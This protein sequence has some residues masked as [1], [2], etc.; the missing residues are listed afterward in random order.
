MP[1]SAPEMVKPDKVTV[2]PVPA[3]LL[4]KTPEAPLVLMLEFTVSP[5][6]TPDNAAVPVLKVAVVAPSYT[7]LLAVTPLMVSV[8]AVMFAVALGWVTV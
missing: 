1:T 8:A 3:V 7:L 4:E 6:T 5:V 2:L